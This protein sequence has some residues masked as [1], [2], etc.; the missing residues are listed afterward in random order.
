MVK[1]SS[2]MAVIMTKLWQNYDVIIQ[3]YDEIMT[4]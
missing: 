4:D 1:I 2:W 3:K